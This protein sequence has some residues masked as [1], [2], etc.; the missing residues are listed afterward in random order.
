[1]KENRSPEGE[2]STQHDLDQILKTRKKQFVLFH[3]GWCPFCVTFLP[4]FQAYINKNPELFIRVRDDG[5]TIA[6]KYLVNVY[7][8]VIFYENAV[9]QRRLDGIL[10][11]GL[12]KEDLSI[13]VDSCLSVG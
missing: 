6:D 8:T 5:E 10:G 3:A 1:M 12:R 2:V 7:P 13:F 9:V 4:L 11:V